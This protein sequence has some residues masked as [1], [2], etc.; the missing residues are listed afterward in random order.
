MKRNTLLLLTLLCWCT[1]ALHTAAQPVAQFDRTAFDFGTILWKKPVTA[2]FTLTNRGDKPLVITYVSTDCGCTDADWTKE[3]IPAGGTGTV[4][5]T[6]D[7]GMLGRFHKSVGVYSNAGD[8]P[9]YLALTGTVAAELENYEEE[10][11]HLIGNLRI[12]RRTIDFAD[13]HKGDTLVAEV[14]VINVGEE[15]MEPLLIHQPSH[16]R[17]EAVP[18]RLGRKQ[19]GKLRFTIDPKRLTQLGLTQTSVYLARYMGDKTSEENE[20]VLNAVLLP[21]FSALT[22]AQQA[23]APDVKLSTTKLTF[24]PF[25]TKKKLTQTLT[26]TN[27]GKS[28]LHIQNIQVDDP[29]VG[30]D[31]KKTTLRPGESTKLKVTAVKSHLRKRTSARPRILMITNAP[32]HPKVVIEAHVTK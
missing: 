23:L 9:E 25:G 18:A 1:T 24:A 15:P 17:M 2:T 31:L 19:A 32:G 28:P 11:P 26:L 16:I 5:A 4:T 14:S 10:Y 12:D 13:G 30:I 6:F 29:A 20:L 27:T 3:A 22:A 8:E 21:D 7:A